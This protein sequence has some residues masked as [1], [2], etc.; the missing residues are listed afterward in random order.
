L[1]LSHFNFFSLGQNADAELRKQGESLL[2]NFLS[3]AFKFLNHPD[4]GVSE[5]T[6]TFLQKYVNQ[7][8]QKK[9]LM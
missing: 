4:D 9:A 8:L 6:I 2:Q 1:F 7:V 5:E 3:L